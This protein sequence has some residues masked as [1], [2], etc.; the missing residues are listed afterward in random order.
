M[1]QRNQME[2]ET[3]ER[4]GKLKYCMA[5]NLQVLN[6]TTRIPITA[7]A[8]SSATTTIVTTTNRTKP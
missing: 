4:D 2:S 1:F 7:T 5:I 6:I 8:T 3:C